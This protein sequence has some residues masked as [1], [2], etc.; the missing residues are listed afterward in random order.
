[1]GEVTERAF[2]RNFALL[3]VDMVSFSIGLTFLGAST[4]LPSLV[5]L[6]GGSPVTVG[7]LGAIQAG[8]WYL[9]QLFVG[10]HMANRPLVKRYIVVP[11]IISRAFLALSLPALVLFG[12]R[13]P[14][15]ALAAFLLCYAGF[16]LVDAVGGVP[17]M[18]LLA[19]AI[20][21]ERRGRAMGTT[22]SL[23]SLA[24]IGVGAV[25]RAV[26]ARPNPFPANYVLLILLA[27]VFCGVSPIASALMREPPGTDT[28]E[29]QPPWREYLPQLLAILRRDARFAWLVIVGWIGGLADMG[30]A[31]YVLFAVDRLHV[32][33][34]MVGLFISAGV[35][36][37]L[38]SGLVLGPIGD[39]KGSATVIAISMAMR[40]LAPALAL[41]TL[42]LAGLHPLAAPGTFL[43]VF[44]AIGMVGGAY[45]IGFTNYLLEIAPPG[46]RSL[47]VALAHTL[48]L[49][50][51][52]A[53]LL[54]GWLVQAVSY[55][56]LFTVTL[57]LAAV[58]VSAALRRPAVA[59]QPRADGLAG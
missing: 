36:G 30:G 11:G 32:H 16:M 34:D 24:A 41:L 3:A 33:P 4:I 57:G 31:F 20:P 13:A 25:V 53:P 17:W 28:G 46:E 48:G 38:V 37:G 1:M 35:V 54:A 6:L 27:A 45:M 47:Y 18:E 26:L 8:G 42:L 43:V 39:R 10:R 9:P 50:V 56:L 23:S 5:R 44:F 14:G 29:T 52:F 12:V 15:L 59:A 22:Q 21:L 58:G 55:E 7:L 51:M 2:R 49:V 19:K 40:C